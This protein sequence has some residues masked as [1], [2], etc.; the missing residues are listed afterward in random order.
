MKFYQTS[1]LHVDINKLAFPTYW[2][3]GLGRIRGRIQIIDWSHC[4]PS[5]P[6]VIVGDTSNIAEWTI[7]TIREAAE[8]FCFVYF[9][10][11]NHDYYGP[12]KRGSR[13]IP[14]V[15][16]IFREVRKTN[17]N[18]VFL[19]PGVSVLTNGTMIIGCMGWYTFDAFVLGRETEYRYWKKGSNDRRYIRFDE[20]PDR[21]AVSQMKALAKTV[22][23]AQDDAVVKE[24]LV[25]THSVP[26]RDFVYPYGHKKHFLNGSYLNSASELVR[27]ADVRGKISH[28]GFG[29]THFWHDRVKSHKH[30]EIRYMSCARG[31]GYD[32]G[33]EEVNSRGEFPVL[34]DSQD[35]RRSAFEI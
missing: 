5:I 11:G 18:V 1:D 35:T 10:P 6:L 4:D 16:D 2:G 32:E 27:E 3:S 9:V 33:I 20:M 12:G 7:R 13:N 17:P 31:Y 25:F 14:V 15:D 34:V 21:K 8:Y 24:I 22:K 29:H 23:A 28:W 30:G 19:E 26:H